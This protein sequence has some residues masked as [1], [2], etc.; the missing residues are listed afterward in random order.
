MNPL[1]AVASLLLNWTNEH[2]CSHSCMCYVVRSVRARLW[3]PRVVIQCCVISTGYMS[4]NLWT[5][6]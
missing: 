4:Q 5:P 3:Q 6:G 1:V 2:S